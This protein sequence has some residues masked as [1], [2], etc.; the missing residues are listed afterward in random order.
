MTGLDTGFFVRLL[1]GH[2]EA[3]R[4]WRAILAGEPS[5]VSC[6]T[7]F[8]LRRMAARGIIDPETIRELVDGVERVALISWIDSRDILREGAD[9]SRRYGIPAFDALIL[10]GLLR[11]GATVIYTSGFHMTRYR[12]DAVRIT[13]LG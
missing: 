12:Q 7:L 4:V 9:I 8:E 3:V 10:A 13:R 5:A 11:C 2:T 6:L 1:E